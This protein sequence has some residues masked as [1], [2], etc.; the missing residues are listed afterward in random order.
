MK[1]TLSAILSVFII[2]LSVTLPVKVNAA[3]E[4]ANLTLDAVS[5]VLMDK[6]T[7][8]ILYADNEHKRL[9][10]ASVTKIMPILLVMEAL[11]KGKI[12][13]TDTVTASSVAASKGGSQIWLK[14]GEQMTVDELLKATVIGSANDACTALGEYIAGSEEGIV[15]MMN[16]RAAELGMKDTFFENCTGLDDDSVN[17]LTSAYDIALMSRELLMHE[18]I[19]TYST[20]WMD[21]LRNGATE[22]VN[23]NKLVRFYKGTTGLKT[24]TTSK[25]GHCI[26]ASAERN[27]LHLIAVVM[28]SSTGNAR[29]ES[30]KALLNWGFAN[31][32]TVTPDFDKNLLT[33]I[34]VIKGIEKDFFPSLESLRPLTLKA[35]IK[36]KIETSV[37]LATDVEAPVEK[38]QKVGTLNFTVDGEQIAQYALFAPYEVRKLKI[39]DIVKRLISS[40]TVNNNRH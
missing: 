20:V 6:S 38:G 4:K 22:L 21:T 25:A 12:N 18:R 13:L 19:S 31:Y 9:F 23:T 2:V 37:E 10:P 36:N 14:E 40:L 32:E 11:D 15:K 26:S 1:K 39:S 8:E 28:G 3:D 7:G 17:H 30:A 5:C 34:N 27:G 35:G 33:K 24:G 29:F 16:D